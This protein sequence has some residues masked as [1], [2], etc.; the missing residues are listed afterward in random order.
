MGKPGAGVSRR[1]FLA[2]AGVGAA[3]LAV[4]RRAAAQDRKTLVVAWDSDVDSLDPAVFKSQGA[5]VTVANTTD[6]P[7]M[8]KVRPMEGK[9][10]LFRSVPGEWDGHLAES[11]AM[12]DNGATIV[13]KVRRGMKFPSGRP[14][15][16]HAFK[17][18]FDRGLLSPGYMKLIFPT[19]IQVSAPEQFV[20]RDDYTFAINM[21]APS[22]MGLDTVALS[23]NA[24]LDPE[25]VKANGTKDDPWATEWLKRNGASI[26]PYRL[27]KN[28]PGVEIVMEAA[29]GYWRPKPYFE[30]VILKLV[31]N[32]ADRVLLLKRKAVD[33]VAGRP[34]LSP[35]N[36]KAL[37]GEPGLKVFSVPDTTCHYLCMNQRKPPFDNKLVRQAVNYAIPIQAILPNVLFGYGIQMKSP[38]PNLTPTYLGDYSPYKH[39][40][41]KA[42]ALMK[43]AGMDKAPIPVDLAVRVGWPTHEQAAVWLQRE[44]EQI[45]FKV[46]IVK[47]TDATFRQ[48]AVKGDHQLSLEAWQSW[49]NDPFY[50]LTFLFNSKSKFTNLSAYSN[51]AVDKLIDD[52]MHETNRD[53]RA[54]ASR[55]VQKLVL[56]DAAWGLLWYENWTRVGTSDLV[57]LEK[58]WDTFERYYSLKRA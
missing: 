46:N 48:I 22:P 29:P 53:K 20:V 30:R 10:G 49:I 56:D 6:A 15:N 21:K 9:A 43:E 31:P 5:Y 32:E 19:L 1:E 38:I 52:N 11:W 44:L 41:A 45:G 42:K 37:E 2:T 12:E 27:V 35:K 18:S 7:I 58:R 55:E 16:A 28:E 39:D 33:L 51:P 50:H 25:L 26:G 8:W 23:N 14:V 40:I 36:V 57:G 54:A 3:G 47:E 24:I 4:G 13:L 17:Y 34:G